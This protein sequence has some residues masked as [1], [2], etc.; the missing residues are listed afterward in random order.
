MIQFYQIYGLGLKVNLGNLDSILA[1]FH[2]QQNK[3][4]LSQVCAPLE[5][6]KK[7]FL[8]MQKTLIL[9]FYHILSAEKYPISLGNHFFPNWKHKKSIFEF[10][11]KSLIV[12]K[13]ELSAG[14]TTFSQA[15]ISYESKGIPFDQKKNSKKNFVKNLFHTSVSRIVSKTKS[16]SQ[17]ALFRLEIEGG[18]SFG[19]KKVP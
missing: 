4:G 2:M 15:E 9:N 18:G 7:Q 6:K 3:S 12:P 16:G 17:N 13:K 11:W 10:F 1:R 5:L 19:L 14:K 8:N